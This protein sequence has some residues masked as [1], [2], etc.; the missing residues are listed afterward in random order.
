FPTV[1]G[2]S[3]RVEWSDSLQPGSW[4]VVETNN[5]P[6]DNIVGTGGTIQVTDTNG[7][8][9]TRRFYRINVE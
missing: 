1:I 7:A 2:K 9:H 3:Y 8:T 4:N 6:Q 5:I